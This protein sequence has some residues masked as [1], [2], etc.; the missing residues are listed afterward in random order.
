[1]LPPTDGLPARSP[2][3]APV[4]IDLEMED[5]PLSEGALPA[6]ATNADEPGVVLVT[7]PSATG[8]PSHHTPPAHAAMVQAVL[9]PQLEGDMMDV[10]VPLASSSAP[11]DAV[12]SNVKGRDEALDISNKK[13]ASAKQDIPR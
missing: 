3:T 12:V 1:M 11:A 6:R 9:H 7:T 5:A 8:P 10:D 2:S 4:A 13:Y